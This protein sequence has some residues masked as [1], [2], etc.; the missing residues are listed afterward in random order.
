M[1]TKKGKKTTI[2]VYKTK[3]TLLTG[4]EVN[5][6]ND[7]CVYFFNAQHKLLMLN[8]LERGYFDFMCEK[9]NARN[10]VE[11]DPEFRERY[12]EFCNKI[13]GPKVSRTQRSFVNFENK[14]KELGLIFQNPNITRLQYV[15]PKHVFK[16]SLWEREKLLK[17]LLKIAIDSDNNDMLK[18]LIDKPL[19][20]LEPNDEL[21][22]LPMP[23]ELLLVE[24][25]KDVR[26]A[27]AKSE[28]KPK[29]IRYLKYKKKP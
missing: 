7:G 27:V 20:T 16:G 12:L 17:K 3:D 28:S 6:V 4:I 2:G 10:L 26:P 5:Y 18:Q 24:E 22:S 19:E 29:R 15:N 8:T 14:L 1:V 13:L 11:V 21:L 23:D 25:I 9:M